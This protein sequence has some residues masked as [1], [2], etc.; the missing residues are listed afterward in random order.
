MPEVTGPQTSVTITE[1][2][3][4]EGQP[5]AATL[6]DYRAM[7]KDPTIALARWLVT[8]PVVASGWSVEATKDAPEGAKDLIEKYF[9]P[10]R[11]HLLRTVM[12]NLIDYGWSPFEKVLEARNDGLI[13]PKKLKPLLHDITDIL[14]FVDTGAFAGFENGE[15]DKAVKLELPSA[16]L[17]S[18]EPEGTNWYGT[19]ALENVRGPWKESNDCNAAASRYD[20]KLAGSQLIVKYPI[21]VSPYNGTDTDNQQ[22]AA[23]IVN[24]WQSSGAV[25]VPNLP[26]NAKDG[27]WEFDMLTDG[28]AGKGAYVERLNYLD[29]L[30]VR[31][32]GLP[33]RSVLEG[34]FGTK[35]EAEE[36]GDFAIVNLELRHLDV[37]QT[38]N[39]H[40]VNQVLRL[41]YGEQYENTVFLRPTPITDKSRKFLR[42]LYGRLIADPN[43]MLLESTK[44]DIKAIREQLGIPSLET[45]DPLEEIV[46]PSDGAP[47]PTSAVDAT[48]GVA[49]AAT[50][51]GAQITAA[52]EIMNAVKARTL[53]ITGGVKLLVA[54]G[55]TEAD[56]TAM[57]QAQLDP[58]VVAAPPK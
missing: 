39:W 38:T 49:A 15:E 50:L 19:A 51:N 23:A 4:L 52:L 37:V 36:H 29:K 55:L 27:K 8:A 22:V 56:A 43:G 46:L 42:E 31:G 24:K 25:S 2:G 45:G 30:K 58:A 57:V 5:T 18:F 40:F 11:M 53:A 12:Y 3:L 48:G 6:K 35:A 20:R 14:V 33:E 16:L 28:G 41:N 21:G 17:Y 9:L 1:D 13:V 44:V 7:R 54:V 10:I 26:E 47:T 34:Q 32:L